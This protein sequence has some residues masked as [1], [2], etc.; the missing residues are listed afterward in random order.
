MEAARKPAP[1]Y[2]VPCEKGGYPFAIWSIDCIPRVSPASPDGHCDV[3]VAICV[4]SKWVEIGLLPR[5][6]SAETTRWF[7]DTIVCRFGVPAAVRSD[8]GSEFRGDFAAYL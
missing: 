4:F 8:R 3:I 5:L 1:P 7:H 2:L 6:T